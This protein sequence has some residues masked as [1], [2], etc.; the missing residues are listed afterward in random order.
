MM[1]VYRKVEP[2]VD[3]VRSSN[4]SSFT[5]V[6][7]MDEDAMRTPH[8]SIIQ[9]QQSHGSPASSMYITQ[10]TTTVVKQEITED[11]EPASSSSSHKSAFPAAPNLHE[12][13][14]LQ[15]MKSDEP[16]SGV[17]T[18]KS[19][20]SESLDELYASGNR[21]S[22][23]STGSSSS[24]SLEVSEILEGVRPSTQEEEVE[25]E[26]DDEEVEYEDAKIEQ[27][28]DEE[29]EEDEV[30]QVELHTQDNRSARATQDEGIL[31]G[32]ISRL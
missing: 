17:S 20:G 6:T 19:E 21:R 7:A 15:P 28:D 2:P 27:E 4:S 30:G 29:E 14:G 10:T 31:Y 8:A 9:S 23:V 22:L 16:I 25:V 12:L 5:Q 18:L 26:D 3:S 1:V 13:E 24:T 11:N 32:N